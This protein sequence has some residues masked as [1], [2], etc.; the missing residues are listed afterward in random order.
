MAYIARTDDP[1]AD[2]NRYEDERERKLSH[3]PRCSHCDNYIQ[4][5]SAYCIEGEYI[6]DE[7]MDMNFRTPIY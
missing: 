6:C 5:E 1:I 4:Q 3:L 7:C 2:F